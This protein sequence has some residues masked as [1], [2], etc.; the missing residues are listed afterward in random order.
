MAKK[1]A[2]KVEHDVPPNRKNVNL[3]NETLIDTAI[4]IALTKL[5]SLE[6]SAAH[7][8]ETRKT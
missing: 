5:K 2:E 4:L 6:L 8:D 3:Q 1:A 7:R